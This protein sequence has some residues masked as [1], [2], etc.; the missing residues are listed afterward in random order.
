MRTYL[1]MD[2]RVERE[3]IFG[4]PPKFWSLKNRDFYNTEAEKFPWPGLASDAVIK[5]LRFQVICGTRFIAFFYYRD[6]TYCCT[7]FRE[8]C[9]HH[10]GEDGRGLTFKKFFSG[11]NRGKSVTGV[12]LWWWKPWKW[13]CRDW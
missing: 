13:N 10:R 6:R 8:L 12:R 3:V 7:C 9:G 2:C 5:P 4:L 11:F 1:Q